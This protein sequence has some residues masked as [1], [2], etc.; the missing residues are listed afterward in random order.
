MFLHCSLPMP[1]PGPQALRIS[2]GGQTRREEASSGPALPNLCQ[3]QGC[4]V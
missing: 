1:N 3:E 4:S 2:E